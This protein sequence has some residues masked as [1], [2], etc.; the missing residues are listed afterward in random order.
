MFLITYLIEKFMIQ[1]LYFIALLKNLFKIHDLQNLS[2]KFHEFRRTYG[3]HS[4][5]VPAFPAQA[6]ISTLRMYP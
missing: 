6:V 5:A 3:P 4:N 1:T 2:L